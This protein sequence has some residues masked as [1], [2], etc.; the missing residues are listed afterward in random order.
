M[1][2]DVDSIQ[3]RNVGNIA[4]VAISSNLNNFASTYSQPAG[5]TYY[6]Y[7]TSGLSSGNWPENSAGFFTSYVG[8]ITTAWDSYVS[9]QEY[10][11]ANSNKVYERYR[12]GTAWQ[13]WTR[14]DI[15]AGAEITTNLTTSN[16]FTSSIVGNLGSA[17]YRNGFLTVT[18]LNISFTSTIDADT[19]LYNINGVNHTI[20]S[21][22][23]V[24]F[25][26]TSGENPTTTRL[27]QFINDGNNLKIQSGWEPLPAAEFY[28]F[29]V[30]I[31]A[32]LK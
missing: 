28:C 30:T 19:A 1:R 32:V 20:P 21:T 26:I 17:S 14:T 13:V 2:T 4:P 5:T 27:I 16:L 15:A 11:P 22:Y 29:T 3:V 7:F 9:R 18:A 12:N 24:P 31:P 8:N 10:R 25:T 6:A 23:S